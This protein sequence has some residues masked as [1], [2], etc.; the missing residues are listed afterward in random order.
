MSRVRQ[1]EGTAGKRELSASKAASATR[2]I[3]K[4]DEALRALADEEYASQMRAARKVLSE[5]RDV[6]R[7]LA[8]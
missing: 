3:K 5:D 8:E 7:K 6:L 1:N 4:Y 2:V